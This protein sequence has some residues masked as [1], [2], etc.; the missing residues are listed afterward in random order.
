M[1]KTSLPRHP[2]ITPERLTDALAE[3]SEITVAG[4]YGEGY[5][6]EIKYDAFTQVWNVYDHGEVTTALTPERAAE[7]F[8]AAR[9]RP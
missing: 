4:H 1:N 9:P 2:H 8:N 5:R 6:V 7:L 3:V